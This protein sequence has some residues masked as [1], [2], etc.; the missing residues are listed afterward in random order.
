MLEQNNKVSASIIWQVCSHVRGLMPDSQLQQ[1]AIAFT[2]LRRID[3]L[4]GQYAKEC[5]S[6]Y[7]KNNETLSEKQLDKKLREISGGYPFYNYS[8]YTFST[9]LLANKPIDVVLNTYLQGFSI[10]VTEFLDG[11]NYR[12]NL[13]ILQRQSR[14]L[15]ELFQLF[16][17][18]DLSASSVDNEEFIELISSIFSGS[19]EIGV[20]H[21]PLELSRLISAC[22]LSED[23][24]AEKG[25]YTTVYDP[26][27]GTGSL[28]S[29]TG[30]KAKDIA[31]LQ[32]EISLYGQDIAIY[33]CAIAKA[34]ALLS[35]N[36]ESTVL[37]G[38]TLTD[39]MFPN[40]KF[41][42]I[43]AEFPFGIQWKP[44]KERIEKENINLS[45]RFHIGLP[46]TNDSQL[47]FVE[48]ILSKMDPRG[49]RAA[50]ITSA[51]ALWGGAAG[52]G[53][54]RIRRWLFENDLVEAIIAL[55]SGSLS[56]TNIPVYLW[57]LSNKKDE[58]YKGKTRLIDTSSLAKNERRF[59]INEKFIKSIVDEYHSHVLSMMSSFV[60]NDDFGFYEVSL[61]E[62]GKKKETV[63][64]PLNTNI[65]EFISKERQ[66]FAKGMISVDYSSVEKGYSI[67]F[68]K[69]LT[70]EEDSTIPLT[71]TAYDVLSLIDAILEIKPL[72]ESS[73][74][75][76]ETEGVPPTWKELPVRSFAELI[77]GPSRPPQEDESGLPLLSVAY[78]RSPESKE[79]YAVTPRSKCSTDK[80]VI[81]ITKGANSGEIFAGMNGILS[82]SV[83]AIRIADYSI[84]TPRYFY[85]LMKGY[86]K[87]LML[88]SKGSSIKSIDSRILS[89]FKCLVPPLADQKRIADYLDSNIAK[90]DPIMKSLKSGDNL[91]AVFR[92]SLIENVVLGKFTM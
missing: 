20:F 22:V 61:L 72:V 84:M 58:F 46:S 55:P 74:N 47:L 14:Y 29:I 75:L 54:S 5:A 6:F 31:A 11:M 3:C 1:I 38:N 66:P 65:D 89:D 78:L 32:S 63:R 91:F 44:F 79:R 12:Q 30:Q 10:N 85:Y 60:P 17:E 21:T 88:L 48:H 92:Q 70:K 37:H 25:K 34:L 56:F 8:G 59:S 62:D 90:I 77:I 39:D 52:S 69:Y 81:I 57:I 4:I 76:I 15:V 41:H 16:A 35:G 83:T 23:I 49:S 51:S 13:G 40:A 73:I 67:Q 42:Y 71:S 36:E 50:F 7:E 33:P 86:E 82:S 19:R 80:D 2:F 87:K 53:E 18:L 68:E 43:V 28:L 24:R 45:G 9:L 27:C 64:I 26:A